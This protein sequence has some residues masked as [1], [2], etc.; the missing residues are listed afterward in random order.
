MYMMLTKTDRNSAYNYWSID[1]ERHSNADAVILKA[2]YLVR[3]AK[4]EGSTLSLTGDLNATT[5]VEILGGA[6][7][8]LS[9]LTFNGNELD[10]KTTDEGVVTATIGFSK[11]SISYPDLGKLAWKY[12]DS[13]PEIQSSYD[14]SAWKDADLKQTYNSHRALNTPT[15]LYGSDYGFHTGTLVFR[16]HFTA[17]GAEKTFFV[18]TQGG[19]AYGASVW[20]DSTFLGSY[21]GSKTADF[22]SSTFTLP[23]T[24][25]ANGTHTLTVIVDNQGLDENWTVGD[26]TSKNPRGIMDFTLDGHQKSD[27]KWKISGNLGG[28]DYVDKTR[29]PLNEGGLFVER[30][31]LHLPGALAADAGWKDSAGPVADGISKPG[32][33]FFGA[34]FKLDIPRG[35]DVPLSFTFTDAS[36]TAYRVQLYVNGWQYGKYVNNIGPQ[37]KFPVPQGILN[38][39]GTNYLGVALWGLDGGVTKL[40]GFSLGP[41]AVIA[42]G[43]GEVRNVEGDRYEA[44]KGAY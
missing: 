43:L 1:Q 19:S 42:T 12:I 13:L 37:T 11:P 41:D 34:E 9:K 14:D 36:T 15:S 4:V 23:T 5:D 3:T 32:V 35:W 2:G 29:G 38:H 8:G 18:I 21:R 31:G 40:G 16:G 33:G 30:Q 22:A 17:S 6:P 20:L 27:V 39:E 7:S 44:R 28:E 25:A 26:E 10:F 24:L